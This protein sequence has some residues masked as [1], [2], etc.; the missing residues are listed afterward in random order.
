MKLNTYLVLAVLRPIVIRQQ[1]VYL[2]GHG[3]FKWEC[4]ASSLKTAKEAFY[5]AYSKNRYRIVSIEN[6][7]VVQLLLPL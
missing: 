1:R 6:T 7:S 5:T 2:R 3:P 4:E